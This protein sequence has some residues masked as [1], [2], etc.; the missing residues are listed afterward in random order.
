MTE[1]KLS[2]LWGPNWVF[3]YYLD[4]LT[5]SL[6]FLCLPATAEMF[7]KF[8]ITRA[9]LS[10][11]IHQNWAPYFRGPQLRTPNFGTRNQPHIEPLVYNGS[12]NLLSDVTHI[13]LWTL[14]LMSTTQVLGNFHIRN[15][16]TMPS[17]WH[18]SP[19]PQL[20][21][22]LSLSLSLCL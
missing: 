7:P 2:F 15:W 13:R 5:A 9:V 18:E 19:L 3:K 11:W 8:K 10:N 14:R 16:R 6:G 12:Q 22:S 17:I 4:E 21:L 1:N 20:S